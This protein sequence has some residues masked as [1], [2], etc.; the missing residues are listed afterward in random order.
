MKYYFIITLLLILCIFL[1]QKNNKKEKFSNTT[2]DNIVQKIS[3]LKKSQIPFFSNN[4][5]FKILNENTNFYNQQYG[6]NLWEKR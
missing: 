4:K 6:Q 2:A 3:G 1:Y 5:N